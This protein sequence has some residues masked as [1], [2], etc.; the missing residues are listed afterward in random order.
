MLPDI[1]PFAHELLR[2]HIQ[3]GDTVLDGTAGNGWDTLF[4]AQCVGDSGC[5]FAFDVQT[6]AL[7]NTAKRLNEHQLQH[8]VQLILAGHERLDE[9]IKQPIAAALFNFGYLP[10]GD[11][12]LTT[13]PETSVIAIDKALKQLKNKGLLLAVVY[14][15]H[16]TGKHEK[17]ALLRFVSTLNHQHY[18]VA[19]YA[20]LNRPHCPP[21]V[22]AI[23]K[24]INEHNKAA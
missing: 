22:L 23:E 24:I 20:W 3:I 17:T 4:L 8:R 11:K 16:E 2:Q 14:H 1:L 7:E 19:Q 12:T 9:F 13:Q 15:G 6:I 21:F 18:K 5:V 10:Q